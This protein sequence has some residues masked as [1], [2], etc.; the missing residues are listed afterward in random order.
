MVG[1]G[2]AGAGMAEAVEEVLGPE[3]MAEKQLTGWVN[4]PD[5]C[6][7]P[8]RRIHLHAPGRRASTSRRPR[9][10]PGAEEILR[11]VESSGR[12][13]SACA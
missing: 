6:V 4:V 13:I 3:L 12:T 7:R 2:K 8:L 10:W 1:A 5:D 9:A 11:L